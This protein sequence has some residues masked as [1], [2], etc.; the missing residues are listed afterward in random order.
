MTDKND[1]DK[2]QVLQAKFMEFQ[3]VQQQI[4]QVQKQIQQLASQKEEVVVLQQS[5]TDISHVEEGSEMFVP[6][7]SGIFAKAKIMNGKELLVNVGN[8]VIVEK[9]VEGVKSMISKQALEIGKVE[10]QLNSNFEMLA[11]HA[12]ELEKELNKLIKEEK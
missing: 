4:Q 7:C 6:V 11:K 1:E 9:N 5:L 12:G 2:K 3:T 8:N 10:E